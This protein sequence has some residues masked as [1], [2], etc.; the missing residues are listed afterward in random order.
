MF[1]QQFVYMT[2]ATTG[3]GAL[4]LV[5]ASAPYTNFD[6]ALASAWSAGTYEVAYTVEEPSTGKWENGIG[7]YVT[8]TKVLTRTLPSATYDGTTLTYAGPTAINFASGSVNVYISD[9]S[10]SNPL[11]FPGTANNAGNL[12]AIT[13]YCPSQW[14]PCGSSSSSA[15]VAGTEYYIATYFN[16][17]HQIDQ[18][19]FTSGSATTGNCKSSL[20]EMKQSGILGAKIFN[21]T[22]AAVGGSGVITSTAVTGLAPPPGWYGYGM[23]FDQAVTLNNC[24]CTLPTPFGQ[25][26]ISAYIFGYTRTGAYASGLPDPAGTSSATAK[27]GAP[28][29]TIN[30]LPYMNFRMKA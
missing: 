18:V 6:T 26:S 15:L 16:G 3:T 21:F 22:T 1:A 30:G 8:S 2:S 14:T 29:G 10:D 17:N 28:N 25:T 13:T 19:S 9:T 27:T 4:T 11:V 24:V 5:A 12:T 20:Y 23:I 7:S